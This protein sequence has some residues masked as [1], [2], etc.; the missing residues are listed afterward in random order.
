MSLTLPTFCSTE[1]LPPTAIGLGEE[2]D[3]GEHRYYGPDESVV[4][5]IEGREVGN[6]PVRTLL[7]SGPP[8]PSSSAG[9]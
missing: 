3:Y 2:P 4:V 9:L 6:I 1:R 5:S 7:V 8:L